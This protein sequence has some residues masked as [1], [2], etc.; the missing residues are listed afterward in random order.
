M[1]D[2]SRRFDEVADRLSA[3]I[4]SGGLRV[5]QRLPS[6]RELSSSLGIGVTT[7][8]AAC[9]ELERRGLVHAKPR[10]GF[11]VSPRPDSI[12][13]RAPLAGLLSSPASS[14]ETT[15]L[16]MAAGQEKDVIALDTAAPHVALTPL[17]EFRA[18]FGRALR[19]HAAEA[20]AYI[21]PPGYAP[22]RRAIARRLVRAGCVLT[23]ED[24]VVTSGASEALLLAMRAVTKPGDFVAVESPTYYGILQVIR[25]L[26][27]HALEVPTD[28]KTGMRTEE[29]ARTLSSRRVAAC[30]VMPNFSNPLGSRMPTEKIERIVEL[31]GKAEVPLIEDDANGELAFSNAR[32]HAAKSF[33]E[34]G[35]VMLCG[36]VSKTLAPG[37]RVG[38]IVPG[39]Y[40]DRVME[41]QWTTTISAS[42]PSQLAV[43]EY[44]NQSACDRHLR[45]LREVVSRNM[46]RFIRTIE[47]HFPRGTTTTRPEGGLVLWVGLPRG[48]SAL[49]LHR[50]ALAEGIAIMP[51]TLFSHGVSLD[52]Y[53]RICC[54]VPW[55]RAV[56]DALVRLGRLCAA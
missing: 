53:V 17:V 14:D 29:L 30:F 39:R 8:L 33:D 37:C 52:G 54:A 50:A 18:I 27:L 55:S 24:I 42:S 16:L 35:L 19:R 41:L 11:Y 28:S 7:A 48:V 4:A 1:R 13:P 51:G 15:R 38:W 44:L 12:G 9:A 49:S 6:V 26:S 56:E 2:R 36:S 3:M 21:F 46:S 47:K 34:R 43:A 22:L 5:G 25:S 23:P 31:L 20:S 10:S 32:P 40:R 45:R